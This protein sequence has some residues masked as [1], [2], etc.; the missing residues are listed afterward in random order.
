MIQLDE[1]M[2]QMG[3]FNHQL[4]LYQRF[5]YKMPGIHPKS[6]NFH[7]LFKILKSGFIIIH[8]EF[9]HLLRMVA[10]QQ[11]LTT[12]KKSPMDLPGEYV[13]SQSAMMVPW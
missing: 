9:R 8:Q 1:H 7:Q 4:V 3:W 12:T 11:W 6:S 5:L 10:K 2:F 13:A